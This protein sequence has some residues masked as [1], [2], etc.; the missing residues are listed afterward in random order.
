MVGLQHEYEKTIDMLGSIEADLKLV[1]A[2]NHDITLDEA[3]YQRKGPYMHRHNEYDED[4]PRKAKELWLGD[5]ARAA[6]ITYLE[7]GTYSFI[8]KNGARLR[9]CHSERPLAR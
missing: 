3:Y 1:I 7:E 4:L 6:G 5:R 2:G 8:L 9:V